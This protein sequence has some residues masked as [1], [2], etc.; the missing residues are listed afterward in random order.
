MCLLNNDLQIKR[1]QMKLR[2]LSLILFLFSATTIFAQMPDFSKDI[3]LAM[4]QIEIMD[5]KWEG[6]G[7]RM[8]P[9]GTKSN[10]DVVENLYFK[11]DSTLLVLEGLGTDD[12]GKAVH[13]AFGII[14]FDPFKKKFQMKSFLSNG[15]STDADFEVVEPN[16]SFK[17]W[18]KP[19]RGGTVK[20]TI[21]YQDNIWTE[22]GEFSKD[23]ENWVKFFEMNLKKIN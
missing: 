20:Y 17:W 7:W 15:L 4:K 9:D 6:S 22:I 23:E 10:S 2:I 11:L 5:G 18:F 16:K 14:S 3:K 12:D 13:N 8:N 21:S 1:C 19:P